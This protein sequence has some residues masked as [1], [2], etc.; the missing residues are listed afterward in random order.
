M[1]PDHRASRRSPAIR[2]H[3]AP[4]VFVVD[5]EPCVT[6]SLQATM[7]TEGWQL[8]TFASARTFLARPRASAPGCL[9]LDVELP[10]MSGLDLQTRVADRPGLPVVFVTRCDDVRITVCAMKAGAL[11]FFPKPV[12]DE[13]LLSAIRHAMDRSRRAL[14]G[15]AEMRTLRERYALLSP[16]EREV[17]AL[18]AVGRLN[19]QVGGELG[20]SEIT[21]KAHRGKLMRKMQAASLVDLVNMA[22]SLNLVTKL[23]VAAD[24]TTDTNAQLKQ[25][26][27]LWPDGAR[28]AQTA[29]PNWRR[30]A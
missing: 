30:N 10:D 4:T 29:P 6:E 26:R 21:V 17:M 16:R 28:V 25:R 14:T 8:E 12:N 23:A 1:K 9:V 11:D 20:I 24:D 5:A 3:S 19:K 2:H 18:V 7:R 27:R 15:E 13:T 22:T